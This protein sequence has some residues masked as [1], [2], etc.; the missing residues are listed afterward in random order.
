MCE[1]QIDGK[2]ISTPQ[3]KAG[4]KPSKECNKYIQ[5]LNNLENKFLL[6]KPP[7]LWY[8]VT[9]GVAN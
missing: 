1:A 3:D 2:Q 7:N 6:H 9:E 5:A 8:F 4:A